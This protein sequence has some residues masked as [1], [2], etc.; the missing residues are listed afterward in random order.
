MHFN[1]LKAVDGVYR[2]QR[3]ALAIRIAYSCTEHMLLICCALGL[4]LPMP[5]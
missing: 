3:E 1:M 5:W 4:N 2:L